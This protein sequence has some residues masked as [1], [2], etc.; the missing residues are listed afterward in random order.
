MTKIKKIKTK[1]MNSKTPTKINDEFSF[2]RD[3][4]RNETEKMT[5]TT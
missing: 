1:R 3:G 2:F 5:R 4:E